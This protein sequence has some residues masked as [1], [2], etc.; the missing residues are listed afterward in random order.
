M[1]LK[2]LPPSKPPGGVSDNRVKQFESTLLPHLT[3]VLRFLYQEA[4]KLTI[5]KGK[6]LSIK[7]ES[8]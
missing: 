1:K 8:K 6:P 2:N 4:N 5:H 7:Y 3:Y